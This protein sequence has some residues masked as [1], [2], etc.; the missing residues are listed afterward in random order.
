MTVLATTH[1][2]QTRLS[3]L[4]EIVHTVLHH[5]LT[6]ISKSIPV[7]DYKS[8]VSHQQSGNLQFL[9]SSTLTVAGHKMV[10]IDF[11]TADKKKNL[12]ALT[13]EKL[14]KDA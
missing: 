14:K 1:S 12:V 7:D 13:K 11:L 10:D 9:R 4:Q 2:K 3:W 8:L 6:V 5:R